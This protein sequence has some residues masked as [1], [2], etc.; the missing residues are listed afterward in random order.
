MTPRDGMLLKVLNHFRV[1]NRCQVE[2]MIFPNLKSATQTANRVLKRLERDGYILQIPQRRDK[3]YIYMPNPAKMHHQSSKLEHFLGLADIY[4][5]FGKPVTFEI[6][7]DI[8]EAYRPDAYMVFKDRHILIEYQRTTISQKK[9]QDKVNRF[10]EA[11]TQGR[12]KCRELCIVS[13]YKYNVTHPKGFA[14]HQLQKD[15]GA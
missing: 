3:P 11:Y 12:H 7:P 14:V 1:L 9:M 10:M 13:N 5:Q 2:K 6:E 8:C 4:L 15:P